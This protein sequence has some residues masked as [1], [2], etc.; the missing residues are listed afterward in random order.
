LRKRN[1]KAGIRQSGG[2]PSGAKWLVVAGIV[3]LTVLAY[4]QVTGNAFINYDDNLYV[5]SNRM[6]QAGLSWSNVVWAFSTSDTGNWIPLTWLSHMLDCQL[7][8][9]SAGGHHLTSLLIHLANATLLFFLLQTIASNLWR[10]AFVAVVFAVH[11]INVESVAWV[12]ERKNVLCTLFCL[13]TIWAYVRYAER[14]NWKRY[15]A[16]VTL[17]IMALMS[18]P[19]AVTLPFVLLLL[20][21]WP[22]DRLR[23]LKPPGAGSSRPAGPAR[24]QDSRTRVAISSLI[25]EKVPF[26]LLALADSMLTLRAQRESGSLGAIQAFPI[27]VRVE[28][29]L[30]SYVD[31]IQKLLWPAHL[32]VFYPYPKTHPPAWEVGL[33]VLLLLGISCL[34]F[35]AARR[36]RYSPVGWL[37]YL[38]TLIPVIGLVQVGGQSM[39]DR[40][41]YIPMLGLLI[42]AAWGLSDLTSDRKPLRNLL[43]V[44]SLSA[45][46]IFAA[47]TRAQV[48]YWANSESLFDHAQSVTENN[49]VAYNNLGEALASRGNTDQAAVWF[50]KAVE[51]NPDYAAGQENMG[52]ALIQQGSPDD[53]IAHLT[54]AT[55]LD[56][57]SYDSLNKLAAALAKKG[58]L[59]DAL[60]LL[61]KALEINP[62]FAP[63]LANLGSVLE[64]QGNLDAAAAAFDKAVQ[65]AGN[66]EMA[67]QF[68]YR[69]G[70]I[71]AKRGD[72]PQAA[73]H[74]RSALRLR[75]DFA[76][77]VEALRKLPVE[78]H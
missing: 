38:G 7:Y 66:A 5:T 55:R 31:Y 46:L 8:G 2:I 36:F 49:Y 63:A 18:K 48:S 35:G 57:R 26:I 21:Y 52:M 11:P 44:S 6:V 70:N 62:D 69:L 74:F 40:Y 28:N 67:V 43:V 59:D 34:V 15:L 12:A 72:S 24:A 56:P 33:A 3:T 50:K 29:A 64:Q 58:Q 16:A 51:A 68:H 73:E 1:H 53:G 27:G 22:L 23:V 17:F 76:P 71:L 60:A 9:L 39:A 14:P 45:T 65:N 75:P 54:M 25:L 61:N 37:W 78:S 30:L 77:A 10:S 47:V 19:M 32:A 13:L 20:D 4:W 41:A 42:L